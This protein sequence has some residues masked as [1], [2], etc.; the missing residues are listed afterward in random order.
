MPGVREVVERLRGLF[1][2]AFPDH[3]RPLI[4]NSERDVWHT[5]GPGGWI[6]D[7]LCAVTAEAVAETV[8]ALPQLLDTADRVAELERELEEARDILRHLKDEVLCCCDACE[9]QYPACARITAHLSK[10][11]RRG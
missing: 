11:T 8:N 9:D 5:G 6:A 3:G 10:E 1:N 7:C 2:A 4:V